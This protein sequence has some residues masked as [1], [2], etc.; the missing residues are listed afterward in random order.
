MAKRKII[1]IDEGR[2]NGCGCC[3][4]A[5]AEGAIEIRDGKARIVSETY[6]DGLGACVGE[7][8]RRALTVIEREAPGFDEAA[9]AR[10]LAPAAVAG[11][12]S[13]SRLA[14]WPVQLALVPSSA[15]FLKGADLLAC[16]DCVPVAVPDFH[17]RFLAGRVLVLG[18]PK[19]DDIRAYRD[20]FAA[21]LRDAGPRSVTVLRMEVPCCSSLAGA[22]LDARDEAAPDLPV[23][24]VT[25][26]VEGG[27]LERETVPVAAGQ[28]GGAA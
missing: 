22:L 10:H 8:P 16:A 6:C 28:P 27:I 14:N 19:F 20:K 26:G 1:M 24:I 7:C 18:C 21:I 4:V 5:C 13:P 15:P 2:C 9:V 25:I 3:L 11:P 17:E 23:E 12:A